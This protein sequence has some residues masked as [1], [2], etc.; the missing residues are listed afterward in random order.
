MEEI[1]LNIQS[2][3]SDLLKEI[4]KLNSETNKLSIGYKNLS[5]SVSNSNNSLRSAS[6][7]WQKINEISKQYEEQSKSTQQTDNENWNNGIK[8]INEYYNSYK[9]LVSNIGALSIRMAGSI[10]TTAMGM[11]PISPSEFSSGFSLDPK[12]L[13][14]F[15]DAMKNAFGMMKEMQQMRHDLAYLSDDAGD[16]S[17]AL[18][19][20]FNIAAGSAISRTTSQGVIR[21]LADQGLKLTDATGK[22]SPKIERLGILAGNLQA[23]TGI[24]ASQWGSFTG[25][26]DFNYG[27]SEAGLNGITSA[28]IGTGLSAQ[29][30]ERTITATNKVLQNTAFIAG[31]PTEKAVLGLTKAVGGAM[32]VFSKFNIPAEKAA[33]LIEGILDPENFQKNS[34]LFARLGISASEYAGYL[35]DANGQQL[36]LEKV[37]GNLPQLA[38]EVS[39]IGNPFARME[40]AKSLGLDMQTVRRFASASRTEIEQIMKEYVEANKNQEA[41]EKKKKKMAAEAA[42]YDDF[43]FGLKMKVLAP[44]MKILQNGMLDRFMAIMPSL[45]NAMANTFIAVAPIATEI[46][47]KLLEIGPSIANFVQRLGEGIGWLFSAVGGGNGVVNFLSDKYND[48]SK[49]NGSFIDSLSD[50]VSILSKIYLAFKAFQIGKF[51]LESAIGI[52]KFVGSGINKALGWIMP[53]KKLIINATVGDLAEAIGREVKPGLG[54]T[55]TGGIGAGLTSILASLAVILAG[56]GIGKF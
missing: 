50:I 56:A 29:Q 16:A 24:A 42:K 35:N 52:G 3:I 10:K 45:A 13:F 2:N 19:T 36:L 47:T 55:T 44:I 41:L 26:L 39:N 27:L 54:R 53:S 46:M 33:T 48:A 38:N 20:V 49:N 37:M 1:K 15:G 23:A 21:A 31:V 7:N 4:S 34:Y 17:K 9:K 11:S 14:G 6:Q 32:K 40:I 12:S 8:K 28:L 30:L 43:I 5:Q 22:A 51:F 25:E 18:N